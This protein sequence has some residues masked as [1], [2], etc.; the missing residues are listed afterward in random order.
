VDLKFELDKTL[1]RDED[2]FELYEA[3]GWNAYIKRDL[4]GLLAI[5]RGSYHLVYVYE[6]EKLVATGRMISDGCL[7]ALV[8]GVG[9][10]PD[11]QKQG[12]GQLVVDNLTHHGRSNNLFVELTCQP[13]LEAYYTRLGFK[14]YGIAMK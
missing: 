2:I 11:Y 12:L 7:S 1:K 3:L 14:Q 4:E 8:C 13:D 6:G 10:H 5:M 9:V